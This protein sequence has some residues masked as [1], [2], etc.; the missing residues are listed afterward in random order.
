MRG[1]RACDRLCILYAKPWSRLKRDGGGFTGLFKTLVNIVMT[2]ILS[3][4]AGES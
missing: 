2:G 3:E 1:G 4:R